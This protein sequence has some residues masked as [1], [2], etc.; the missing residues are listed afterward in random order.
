M[1]ESALRD[2]EGALH[3]GTDGCFLDSMHFSAESMQSRPLIAACLIRLGFRFV[4]GAVFPY[5]AAATLSV[6]CN[7]RRCRGQTGGFQDKGQRVRLQEET[8]RLRRPQ[9]PV[10]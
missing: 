6:E 3:S 2:E 4:D 1:P 5:R 8:A 7:H 10:I 9:L